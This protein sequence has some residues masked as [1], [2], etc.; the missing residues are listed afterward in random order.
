MNY[1]YPIEE[2]WSKEEIIDV[3]Q[4]YELIEKA[5]EQGTN[6]E[7]LLQAYKRFK[8]IVPSKSEEKTYFRE[9]EKN[10]GYACYKVVQKAKKADQNT[11]IKL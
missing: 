2:N 8:Q 5:Y 9:F 4:F 6:A 1:S 7:S 10:A 3:I 11:R